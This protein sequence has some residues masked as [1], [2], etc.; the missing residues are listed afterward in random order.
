MMTGRIAG[1]GS[2]LREI[3]G[4]LA[5]ARASWCLLL[6]LVA[7][8]GWVVS[9]G[10]PED[11]RWHQAL[12]LS[13]ETAVSGPWRCFTY[14]WLHGNWTHLVMNGVFLLLLGAGVEHFS[15]SMGLLRIVGFGILGG[16]AGH[17]LLGGSGPELPLL[18]GFS[19]AGMAVLLYTTTLSPDS[20]MWPV[21]VSGRSL[22]AGILIAEAML[23]M[24]NPQA[25][26]PGFERIGEAM[27]KAGLGAWFLV[28][29]ACHLGGGLAGW[30]AA[31]WVLRG[32]VTLNR[33]RR[34]RARR[35]AME[36]QRR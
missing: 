12:G 36:N 7:V 25:G 23:A 33:L 10:F 2:V 8:H 20:R 1:F 28:G 13:R 31:R 16:A 14:A 17:L 34:E 9:A 35:E 21:P 24:V 27:A 15:G 5:A 22:G 26:I 11:G 29:H 3:G 6:V 18:V 30:L 4:R 19:G 32:R